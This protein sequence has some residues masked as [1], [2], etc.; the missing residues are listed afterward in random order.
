M[1][2]RIGAAG[3]A[4]QRFEPAATNRAPHGTTWAEP[5][6]AVAGRICTIAMRPAHLGQRGASELRWSVHSRQG[7]GPPRLQKGDDPNWQS[8]KAGAADRSGVTCRGRTHNRRGSGGAAVPPAHGWT[9]RAVWRCAAG[10]RVAFDKSEQRRV[11]AIARQKRTK[12][13]TQKAERCKRRDGV[14]P[15]RRVVRGRNRRCPQV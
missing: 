15:Y 9:G 3:R 1:R 6:A 14:R 11:A 2:Q 4:V 12:Q 8:G 13:A 7:A 10:K 5:S